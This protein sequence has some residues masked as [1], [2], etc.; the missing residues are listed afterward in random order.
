MRDGE[1]GIVK[2][3]R[4][5]PYLTRKQVDEGALDGRGLELAYLDDPVD[6]FFLQIQG[7][8]RLDWVEGGTARA[9]F[10]GKSGHPYKSVAR[11]MIDKGWA[12][13]STAS[14]GRIRTFVRDNPVQGRVLLQ[15]N[16]SFVF[17]RLIEGLDDDAGP[18]GALGAQLTAGRSVA[19]DRRFTPLGAPIWL[20]A[21]GPEGPIRR[22]TVAQDVG[23]AILGAQ[24]ADYYWGSG[25]AAGALAG[26]MRDR[27]GRVTMLLPNE[28]ARRLVAPSS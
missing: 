5:V 13:A 8:G 14:A 12:T 16:P 17:F 26:R 24:R 19:V 25:D 3:G 9:G 2:N 21:S 4:L 1:Y 27:D 28:L 10:A 15:E 11:A 20:E 23:S 6:A 18:V 7:S 22:L